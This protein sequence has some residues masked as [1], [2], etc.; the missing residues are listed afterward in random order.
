M[1]RMR[2]LI[3]GCHPISFGILLWV[4]E[5]DNFSVTKLYSTIKFERLQN[6][7]EQIFLD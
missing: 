5:F 3:M 7:S 6:V 4:G 2:C 1:F